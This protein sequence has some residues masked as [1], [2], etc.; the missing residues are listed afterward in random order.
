MHPW[1][2]FIA[3]LAL[4]IHEFFRIINDQSLSE[5]YHSNID[6]QGMILLFII[7]LKIKNLFIESVMKMGHLPFEY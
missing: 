7:L 4:Q 5:I 2:S 6:V 1:P 3:N